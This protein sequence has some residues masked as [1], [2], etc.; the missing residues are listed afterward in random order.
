MDKTNSPGIYPGEDN[1]RKD[2]AI[3]GESFTNNAFS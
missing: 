2:K 1:I 3:Y